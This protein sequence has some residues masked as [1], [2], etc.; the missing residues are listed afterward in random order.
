MRTDMT[1]FL[2][3][4]ML[5]LSLVE[6]QEN[7]FRNLVDRFARVFGAN[8]I[9]LLL[10]T[11]GE[12]FFRHWGFREAPDPED[13][14]KTQD[15]KTFYA[16]FRN[17]DLGFLYVEH[18][19]PLTPQV[20][21]FYRMTLPVL[22][23]SLELKRAHIRLKESEQWYRQI[24][25]TA[26]EGIVVTDKDFG[27]VEVSERFEE[28]LGY[29]MK[30]LEGRTILDIV[31]EKD[32]R[33]LVEEVRRRKEGKSSVYEV[34]FRHKDGH[35][36]WIRVSCSPIFDAEGRF[37]GVLGFFSDIDKRKKTESE[38][39]R[40]QVFFESLFRM[41]PEAIVVVDTEHH[42]IEINEAFTRL[43]GFAPEES[44]GQNLDDVLD[45]GKEGSADKD[46][47]SRILKGETITAK[48]VRYSKEGGKLHVLIKA[49]PI[50]IGGDFAGAIVMYL[51]ITEQKAYESYLKRESHMDPLTGLNNRTYFEKI[52]KRLKAD[53]RAFPMVFMVIDMD[54][55][56]EVNDT[57]GHAVGDEYLEM[58]G[59]LLK[60]CV[61]SEDTLARIGGDEFAIMLPQS[62][63]DT[64]K[65]LERR[66][67]GAIRKEN[68]RRGHELP[69]SLS[70]GFAVARSPEE[71]FEDVFDTADA[72][73]YRKKRIK[74]AEK[75]AP[76][77]A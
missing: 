35:P 23:E 33:K 38:K 20:R 28:I 29:S 48:T 43:F 64:A 53:T 7:F 16:P 39:T 4:E 3:Y 49:S 24:F 57:F 59:Y 70:I 47:S 31:C 19:R 5:T 27:L 71:D 56:K 37:Q 40:Q 61:R 62:E 14:K 25:Q 55:L 63:E 52:M 54:N 60:K 45:T 9:A 32:Y 12:R 69:L 65:E 8:R 73:M 15:E 10:K 75:F 36:V 1:S 74:K 6:G 76:Y 18:T 34:R 67:A 13:L 22:E 72:A 58:T 46:L 17:G 2:L 50:F 44:I 21:V 30:D 77:R 41:V 42:I 26:Y 66:I 68:E 51:D 11:N